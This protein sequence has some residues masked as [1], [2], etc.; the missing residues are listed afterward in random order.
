MDATDPIR[1]ALEA[2]QHELTALH[3]L[4]AHDGDPAQTWQVD[5]AGVLAQLDAALAALDSPPPNEMEAPD[6]SDG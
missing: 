5:T 4:H 1:R 3:G 6:G 2:A